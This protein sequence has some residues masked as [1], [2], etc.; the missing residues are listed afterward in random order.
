MGERRVVITGLGLINALG[1]GR[2][3][4][5]KAMLDGRIGIDRIKAFDPAGFPC[6]IGGEAP[7]YAIGDFVPKSHRKATKLMSRDIALSVIAATCAV[8]DAGLKT[9]GTSPEG[10]I[11]IDPTR[12]GVNVGAGLICCDI[13]ELGAAAEH[14]VAEGRFSLAEWGSKGMEYLTPLWLLKYLPNML[15]CHI[16]IIHDLQG[17][18]NSITCA[19][20]SGLLA[21]GEAFRTIAA[22]KADLMVAGGAECKMNPMG[23]IRQTLLKRMALDYNGEPQSGCRPFDRHAGG[24]VLGEGGGIVILED[25]E[26]ARRRGATI[27]A[28][29]TGFGGSNCFCRNFVNL[30]PADTGV[31]IAIRKA[32]SDAKLAPEQIGLV[33]PHGVGVRRDDQVEAQAIQ[34]VFGDHSRRVYTVT[35]KS[36]VGNCG[37][38]SGAID[39]VTAILA[40]AERKIPPNVNCPDPDEGIILPVGDHG[41][42]ETKIEHALV[43]SYTYGGQ[44]AAITVSQPAF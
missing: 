33:I 12:S 32:L 5:F 43:S 20:A 30:D 4:Y 3:Q 10:P 37:A 29:L 40:M 24:A 1:V 34:D 44:T 25:L 28:E 22:G 41:V 39:L 36:R 14:A 2:E 8:R 27:Y 13:E 19:D 38:G 17:P 31:S 42:I 21:I 6:Q 26:H 11:D 7:D 35:T 23:L 15:S 9:K 16:S 18:S